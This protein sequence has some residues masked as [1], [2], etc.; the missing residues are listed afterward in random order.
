MFSLLTIHRQNEDGTIDGAWL[1]DVVGTL[2][3]AR[4]RAQSTSAVN[5]GMPIAVVKAV[6]W[7]SP[8]DLFYAQ[9]RL[10]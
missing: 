6:G 2:E 10:A 7:C 4:Q 8:C 9:T 1:Q 3:E 5:S